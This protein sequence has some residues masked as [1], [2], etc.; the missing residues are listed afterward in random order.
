M[1]PKHPASETGAAWFHAALALYYGGILIVCLQRVLGSRVCSTQTDRR[2]PAACATNATNVGGSMAIRPG[3]RTRISMN[4]PDSAVCVFAGTSQRLSSTKSS[5]DKVADA[6]S[7]EAKNIFAS[8][9]T[10][11]PAR[12]AECC[13]SD[14]ITVSADGSVT[15]SL[16]PLSSILPAVRFGL[17]TLGFWFHFV[18]TWRHWRDRNM[19]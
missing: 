19:S 5:V 16:L 1:I 12:D 4:R 17:Y 18:S 11:R 10:T 6:R 7:A 13:A 2:M 15:E 14:A 9:M 3:S 8:T